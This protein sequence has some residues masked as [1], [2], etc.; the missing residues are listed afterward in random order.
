MPTKTCV[1][2]GGTWPI[3]FFHLNGGTHKKSKHL[4]RAQCIGCARKYRSPDYPLTRKANTSIHRHAKTYG[5]STADFASQFGWN[6]KRMVAELAHAMGGNC[7]YCQNPLVE[8]KM[9]TF[10][11][12]DP[13]KPPNYSSNVR[14]C[15]LECNTSK[16]GK[17]PEAWAERV[18]TWNK[19]RE[20][21][22][23]LRE[24]PTQNLPLFRVA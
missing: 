14:I 22:S 24:N 6:P 21:I 4:P 12:I 13:S 3:S 5:L 15:C 1:A 19:Y 16:K 9:L 7:P 10:D 2:C 17:S 20:W 11:I 8:Q 18:D 23:K